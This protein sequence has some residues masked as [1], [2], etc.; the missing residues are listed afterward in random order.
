M[1]FKIKSDILYTCDKYGNTI[2]K[3]CDSVNYASYSE[4]E[5]IFVITYLNGFVETRDTY[6][7]RIRKICEGA[8]EARFQD[9]NI[10]VRTKTDTQLRDRYGNVIR[11]L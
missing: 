6:G 2:R 3:I 9:T 11:K 10:V 1:E 8:I 5:K 7:N 4:K